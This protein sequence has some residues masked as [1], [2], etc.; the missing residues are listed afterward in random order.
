M[1]ESNYV[2]FFNEVFSFIMKYLSLTK[3]DLVNQYISGRSWDRCISTACDTIKTKS[4]FDPLISQNFKLFLTRRLHE[5]PIAIDDFFE[6]LLI[7]IRKW[8]VDESLFKKSSDDVT[9]ILNVLEQAFCHRDVSQKRNSYE[10]DTAIHTLTYKKDGTIELA[11]E[12]CV[13]VNTSLISIPFGT[14]AANPIPIYAEQGQKIIMSEPKGGKKEM[15]VTLDREYFTGELVKSGYKINMK[16]D[17]DYTLH[18]NVQ[19][20]VNN[21][22]LRVIFET[23]ENFPDKKIPIK[24]STYSCPQDHDEPEA[25]KKVFPLDGYLSYTPRNPKLGYQYI[26][27][28][29]FD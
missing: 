28:W 16:A 14:T 19:T 10:F 3:N 23:Y 12:C 15:I 6:K 25:I 17:D 5:T 4:T 20:P 9:T 22:I 7:I 27:Q 18:Y 2:Y 13:R 8:N 21:L 24:Y 29:Y 26:I 1:S 11:C